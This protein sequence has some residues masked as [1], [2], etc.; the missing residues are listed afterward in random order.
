MAASFQERYDTAK[1]S[2][3]KIN[4]KRFADLEAG[5]TI[6]IPSPADI[7]AEIESLEAEELIDLT[8]LRHRLAD[9]H[10]ADGSCPVMTGMNLRIVA[11][12]SL[13]GLDGGA[14]EDAV[15]PVWK[16]VDPK[17][18]LAKK[19]PGGVARITALRSPLTSTR[20]RQGD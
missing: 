19:L 15:V 6:L 7:A 5:T 17:S 1:P 20:P 16:V 13:E 12:I 11:E 14:P 8:E 10:G 3:I 9:R 4:D 2:S 18:A